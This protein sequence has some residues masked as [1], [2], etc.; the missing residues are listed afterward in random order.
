LQPVAPVDVV[1]PA[2]L[3]METGQAVEPA[4]TEAAALEMPLAENVMPVAVDKPKQF[5]PA[6]HCA[7][8]IEA[9]AAVV[10]GIE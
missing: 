9:V 4:V 7:G 3:V 2:A 8:V 1:A 5:E 10:A 6:A